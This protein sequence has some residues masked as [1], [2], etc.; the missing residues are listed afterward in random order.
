[1][2]VIVVLAIIVSLA[3]PSYQSQMSKNRRTDGQ[4]MLLEIKSIGGHSINK[5]KTMWKDITYDIA[6]ALQ[7]NKHCYLFARAETKIIAYAECRISKMGNVY[8]KKKILHINSI[9]T[10]PP[11]HL[12]LAFSTLK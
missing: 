9:Y 6:K 12:N 11:D 10:L 7:S 2:I 8:E 5:S 4:K 1:M 3:Y